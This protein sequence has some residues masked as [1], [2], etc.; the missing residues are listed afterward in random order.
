MNARPHL[1]YLVASSTGA[2]RREALV[3][4]DDLAASAS[5]QRSI[6]MNDRA[7]AIYNAKWG[8]GR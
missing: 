3:S 4:Q 5:E 6:A 2:H 7:N 1:R 8:I